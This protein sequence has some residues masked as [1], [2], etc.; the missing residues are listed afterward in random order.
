MG[1]LPVWESK[2]STP[3]GLINIR[4]ETCKEKPYFTNVL[5]TSRCLIP[6]SGFF[7]R[8][9]LKL[10]GKPETEIDPARA[11]NPVEESED[12]GAI[13]RILLDNPT[14]FIQLES[15][16]AELVT[17]LTDINLDVQVQESQK[18]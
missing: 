16:L 5:L 14:G 11:R 13:S 18:K 15:D 3:F 6:A 2:K 9:E 7:E 17:S 1:I 8:K 4:A 12:I 10:E